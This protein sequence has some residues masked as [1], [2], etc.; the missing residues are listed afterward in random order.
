MSYFILHRCT[1]EGSCYLV[2]ASTWLGPLEV[3]EPVYGWV[4]PFLMLFTFVTN[5][6]IITGLCRLVII[7][8]HLL[9]LIHQHDLSAEQ[10]VDEVPHQ[11][12][13]PVHGRV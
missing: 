3:V 13:A 7:S 6:L 10:G 8:L 4:M 5:T 1:S 11:H 9:A 2:N 12:S